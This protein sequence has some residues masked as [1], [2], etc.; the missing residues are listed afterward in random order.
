VDIY[1][2]RTGEQLQSP[3]V[4]TY[5]VVEW[6]QM[7]GRWIAPDFGYYDT[8]YGQDQIWF[9][10][11]GAALVHARH[12]YWEQEVYFSQEAGPESHNKRSLWIWPV[13]NLQFKPRLSAQIAA[14]PTIPLNHAQRWGYD[15]DRAK[16]EWRAASHW[17]TGVGYSGGICSTRTWQ[18][19]PFLSATRK[20]PVGNFEMW[21]QRIPGGGQVQMRYLLVKQEH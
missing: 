15:V 1:I 21:L 2:V 16:L 6:E 13:M 9:A 5:R 10:G 19:E 3:R 20:T 7:R 8:G 12:F 17:S 14:Y 18:S 11:G 4:V